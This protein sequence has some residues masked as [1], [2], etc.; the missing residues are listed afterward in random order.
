[1][2]QIL[3]S[4][5][6]FSS[7]FFDFVMNT[8]MDTLIKHHAGYVYQKCPNHPR[9]DIHGRIL[10]H[11]LVVEKHY[12]RFLYPWESIHHLNGKKND[13]RI[14]NLEI[15]IGQSQHMKRHAKR[16]NKELIA[17]VRK[18][19]SDPN[20]RLLDLPCSPV[21]AQWICKHNNIQWLDAD[22][23]H[24]TKDKT[25]EALAGKTTA[26]AAKILGVSVSTLHRLFPDLLNKRHAP[27]FLDKHREEIC[28]LAMTHSVKNLTDIFSTNRTTINQAF[29]RWKG[30][31][32]LPIE[33]A[34][35]LN[36]NPH[37]KN[38]L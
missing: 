5:D 12:G 26:Q 35:K 25:L 37:R 7:D 18:A 36:D 30:A 15:V 21:V 1:M 31:G 24:L 14:E 28:N 32:V 29:A 3:P 8:A 11:R 38:K 16:Y 2:E 4:Q 10:Q 20:E 6:S 9:C 23:T 34:A 27:C 17:K 33:L 19:A 22:K 13:N